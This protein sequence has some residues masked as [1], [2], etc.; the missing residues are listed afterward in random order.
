MYRP[1]APTMFEP[2]NP[3]HSLVDML[4]EEI[5]ML[6]SPE[7]IYWK[8]KKPEDLE[9]NF[10]YIGGDNYLDEL[11]KEYGE[12]S[13]GTGKL[14]HYDP[15]R[16]YGKIDIEPIVNELIRLGLVT[17]RDIAFYVNIAHIHEKLGCPPKAGDIFRVTYMIRDNNG[18]IKYKFVYYHVANVNEVDIYNYQYINY[19]IWAEPTNMM[20]V[21]EIIKQYKIENQFNN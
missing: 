10:E 21:Q 15:V 1:Q 18:D 7:I 11:D 12:K 17:K 6:E 9:E 14:L 3:E 5:H 2:N 13:S 4:T 16:V 8:L 19:Q 20:D